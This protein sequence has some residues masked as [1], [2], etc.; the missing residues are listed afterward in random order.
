MPDT[1]LDAPESPQ[2]KVEKSMIKGLDV[3]LLAAST[4]PPPYPSFPEVEDGEHGPA[5]SGVDLAQ[6][7]EESG[8]DAEAG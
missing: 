6:E 7:S 3:T 5:A 4:R 2:E 8:E 1:T